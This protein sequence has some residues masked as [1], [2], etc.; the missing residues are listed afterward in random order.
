[1][2]DV[3][4]I[5]DVLTL[6]GIETPLPTKHFNDLKYRG[7]LDGFPNPLHY[8]INKKKVF[9]KDRVLEWINKSQEPYVNLTIDFLKGAYAHPSL[10]SKWDAKKRVARVNRP[11]TKTV[12]C[13]GI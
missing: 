7:K 11:K 5:V 2:M 12:K 4:T 10:K 13:L 6:M 3:V 1:M 8:K 9:S